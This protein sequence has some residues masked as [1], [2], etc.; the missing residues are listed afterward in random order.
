MKDPVYLSYFLN[1]ETP[2]YGGAENAFVIEKTNQISKGDNSNNM[3][4]SFPNHI[5][6]HIDFPIHF[7]ANGLTCSDYPPSFWIFRKIGFLE[8]SVDEIESHL[9]DL[10]NDIEALIL[11]TGFGTKRM[12]R[13]YWAEQPVIPAYL[14][15]VLKDRFPGLRLFGFDLISLTSKLNR[16]EGRKAHLQFLI[17]REILVLEDMNLRSLDFNPEFMIIAPLQ[18]SSADG[19]PCN[20]IAF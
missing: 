8:C 18:V 1:A 15:D 4:L 5:G 13:E 10:P 19:V 11:K 14:A 6:T 9:L 16:E 3:H 7:S 20:V 17:E 12:E 2:V